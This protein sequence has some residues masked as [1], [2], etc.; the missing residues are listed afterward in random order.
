VRY[1][2]WITHGDVD[3]E[4]DIPRDSGA[5][6]RHGLKKLAA[7]RDSAGNLYERSAVCTHLGCIVNWNSGEKTWD[8]PCHG[9]RFD[10][11]GALI[12]GPATRNLGTVESDTDSEETPRK[13]A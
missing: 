10:R 11:Y 9:S 13:I 1:G 6:V 4:D 3:T 12:N 2:A 7:Y 8:C 5:I